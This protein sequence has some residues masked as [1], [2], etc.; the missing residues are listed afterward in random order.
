MSNDCEN[1]LLYGY[2]RERGED[3]F[4]RYNHVTGQST[5]ISNF[6][7]VYHGPRIAPDNERFAFTSNI[8]DKEELWI[9][10][11]DSDEYALVSNTSGES[12]LDT[13]HF[14]DFRWINNNELSIILYNK[15]D[16]SV[17]NK[18]LIISIN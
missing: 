5:F 6:R 1:F 12:F 11:F 9:Y 15:D 13:P 10:R 14:L 7:E 4:Y 3:G 18:S 16:S 2:F 17:P 8:T